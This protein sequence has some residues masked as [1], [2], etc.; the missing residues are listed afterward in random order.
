MFGT[1]DPLGEVETV[2]LQP[3]LE[4]RN[5]NGFGLDDIDG[6]CERLVKWSHEKAEELERKKRERVSKNRGSLRMKMISSLLVYIYTP[7]R[8]IEEDRNSFLIDVSYIRLT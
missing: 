1:Q 7:R 5:G 8:W 2:F 3:R 6:C 4:F